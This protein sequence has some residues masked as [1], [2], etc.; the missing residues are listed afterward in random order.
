MS[1]CN[2]LTFN[3]E[4]SDSLGLQLV[5]MITQQIGGEMVIGNG[6]GAAFTLTF[7]KPEEEISTS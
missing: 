1:I 6:T 2:A 5:N 3:L 4:E 7:D